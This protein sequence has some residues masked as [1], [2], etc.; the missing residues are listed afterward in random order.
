MPHLTDL[1]RAPATGQLQH[2]VSI[3]FSCFQSIFAWPQN[4]SLVWT[5]LALSA[6][7]AGHDKTRVRQVTL[8]ILG[9]VDVCA[10]TFHL[11]S[12]S[13][14]GSVNWHSIGAFW[15]CGSTVALNLPTLGIAKQRYKHI[16]L[17]FSMASH[18]TSEKPFQ[19]TSECWWTATVAQLGSKI[20]QLSTAWDI[21]VGEMPYG[22]T[23]SSV[24]GIK[25]SPG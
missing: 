25:T 24:H 16:R 4:S 2:A 23:N 11:C 9:A 6:L 1:D 12:S 5:H 21:M 22:R 13:L 18:L 10:T 15:L 14:D 3:K 7:G 8:A 17:N 20:H 19:I